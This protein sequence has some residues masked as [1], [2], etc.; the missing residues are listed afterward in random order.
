MLDFADILSV[1]IAFFLI[2]VSPGPANIALATISMSSGRRHGLLFAA[3]LSAG[4]AFW[5]VVAATG[6]G[7]ILQGSVHL[8][9]ALKLFGGIYLLWLAWRS[10]RSAMRRVDDRPHSARQDHWFRR[11]LLLNLS[12]PKAVI[13]WMAAL[14]MG[15]GAGDG[16]AQLLVATLVCI[17][18]GVLNYVAYA[19]AF[20]LPGF[21]VA[22]QRLR[23]L[24]DGA[25]SALFALAGLGLIR[26]A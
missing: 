9:S 5:G 7:A 15:L 16:I 18:L 8:L 1:N 10:G 23:R 11:G 26:S 13:A 12:N 25:V 2:T 3:G 24:I 6:L 22:Y 20:S 4:L 14:S 19:V 21:M 17:A